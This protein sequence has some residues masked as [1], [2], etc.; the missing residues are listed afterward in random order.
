MM[1][2]GMNV[3][4][5]KNDSLLHVILKSAPE[6]FVKTGVPG[7][8]GLAGLVG[9]DSGFGRFHAVFYGRKLGGLAAIA[10]R[11][12]ALARKSAGVARLDEILAGGL[13]GTVRL[14]AG[15]RGGWLRGMSWLGTGGVRLAAGRDAPRAFALPRAATLQGRRDLFKIISGKNGTERS[16]APARMVG[17]GGVHERFARPA[18]VEDVRVRAGRDAGWRKEIKA[19]R[20]NLSRGAAREADG[21]AA[22]GAAGVRK[23]GRGYQADVARAVKDYFAHQARL[24]P[25]GAVAFD[26]RLT[27]AWAGL[28]L[29]V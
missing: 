24:P 14:G 2:G 10:P 5:L 28:K 7:N 8:S 23:E 9:P 27:P 17:G 12:R 22:P 26:P 20:G 29:P 6:I 13:A 11:R 19:P 18:G 4:G 25:A 15:V 3:G 21:G 1:H 16:F